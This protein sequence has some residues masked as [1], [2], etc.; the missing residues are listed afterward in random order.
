M[1]GR[2]QYICFLLNAPIS[3]I[4]LEK[5]PTFCQFYVGEF[6]DTLEFIELLIA[7]DNSLPI[8]EE[9]T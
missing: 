7:S 1:M 2:T 5:Q 9:I 4:M 8:W 6:V 3:W